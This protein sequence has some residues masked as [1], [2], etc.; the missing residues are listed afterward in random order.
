MKQKKT[1]M[2]RREFSRSLAL[3]AATAAVPA[4]TVLGKETPVPT[5]K[6][7]AIAGGLA[8]TQESDA[9]KLTPEGEGQYQMLLSRYG[10]RLSDE[11][12]VDA[13]RL[14]KGTQDTSK[15]MDSFKLENW[16]EP[17]P[18]FRVYRSEMNTEEESK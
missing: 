11:Q 1:G 17:A 3:I 7:P 18:I 12:K 14:I 16:N 10:S 2:S 5:P 13:R 4:G 15:T 8:P 9:S 6:Q